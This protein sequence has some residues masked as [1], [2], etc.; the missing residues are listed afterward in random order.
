MMTSDEKILA[1]V[2]VIDEK[3][4]LL[5][6]AKPVELY[7]QEPPFIEC[8][9]DDGIMYAEP[10]T[11]ISSSELADILAKLADD[12]GVIE[13]LPN[14]NNGCFEIKVLPLFKTYMKH[15]HQ[16]KEN[17]AGSIM[18]LVP[19]DTKWKDIH[20]QISSQTSFYY[21]TSQNSHK[22]EI[23]Y[24]T[25]GLTKKGNTVKPTKPALILLDL[26]LRG[27]LKYLDVS[28][29]ELELRKKQKENLDKKLRKAFGINSSSFVRYSS[30]N[31]YV[32]R[33]N[34]TITENYRRHLQSRDQQPDENDVKDYEHFGL[35]AI[36]SLGY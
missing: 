22:Q 33:F 35:D 28:K 14:K 29:E 3:Q 7:C 23:Q 36:D 19:L 6:R 18:P 12:E 5:P 15:L 27:P 31:G 10:H 16:R 1:I 13:V 25:I 30:Q 26:C 24:S 34:I 2:G 4:K 32:P 8:Y 17:D 9:F 21:W 11:N 20:M